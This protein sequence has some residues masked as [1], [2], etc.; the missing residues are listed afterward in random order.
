MYRKSEP[1]TI[2][3]GSLMSVHRK[4][5]LSCDETGTLRTLLLGVAAELDLE[6]CEAPFSLPG[7]RELIAKRI[8]GVLVICGKEVGQAVLDFLK[9]VA[10]ISGAPPLVI[11]TRSLSQKNRTC[12]YRAGAIGCLTLD[13]A[14]ESLAPIIKR[15]VN[16]LCSD[17]SCAGSWQ[18]CSSFTFTAP[19]YI[20]SNGT[21]VVQLP[22]IQGRIFESLVSKPNQ[23]VTYQSLI[24]HAW[25]GTGLGSINTLHQQ[26]FRLRSALDEGVASSIGCVRGR[27][28]RFVPQGASS[29]VRSTGATGT[30]PGS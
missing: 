21:V 5:L 20:V 2:V 19:D 18:L 3:E 6:F 13:E 9:G 17:D 12:A 14:V 4:H 29:A 22:A 25:G 7:V 10:A 28:Y 23:L 24:K 16:H 30:D 15:I 27:G 11:V 1:K 26:V 8:Q